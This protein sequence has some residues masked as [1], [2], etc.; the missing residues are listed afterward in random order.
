M[1]DRQ[2]SLLTQG[3]EVVFDSPAV[4]GV[5]NLSP[6]SFYQVRQGVD[7][8]V[9]CV[10]QMIK[11]GVS[12][13]DLGAEA[14]NPKAILRDNESEQIAFEQEQLL[15]VIEALRSRFDVFLSVDTSR[16]AVM[17]SVAKAGA[18][19]IN[20]QRALTLSGAL[21]TAADSGLAVCLMHSFM[22]KR[23]P[24]SSSGKELVSR[25]IADLKKQ[26]NAC[27]EAGM[28]RKSIIV[29]PGFGQ[30]HYGKN[31]DENLYLLAHLDELSIINLPILAGWSRKSM[32]GDILG[33]DVD[34]RL[35]GSLAA[36]LIAAQKGA[37]IIRAHD[38]QETNDVCRFLRFFWQN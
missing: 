20:D 22:P 11:D 5:I 26:I 17:S 8:V 1:P 12:I 16:A 28:S 31:T 19:M 29:D 24:G 3:R 27:E 25:I 10:A 4:M 37:H 21:K 18:D 2:F 6:D 9:E 32:L 13:I 33:R 36:A 35:A 23:E 34:E 38:V 14:T 15:P 30:G 7:A